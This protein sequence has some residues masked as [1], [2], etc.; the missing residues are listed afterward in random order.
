MEPKREENNEEIWRF[1]FDSVSRR[2]WREKILILR[3]IKLLNVLTSTMDNEEA[4]AASDGGNLM[5]WKRRLM[6][7]AGRREA[8]SNLTEDDEKLKGSCG[9]GVNGEKAFKSFQLH[10]SGKLFP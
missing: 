10:L 6:W 7:W 9:G 4:R 5:P 2:A 3:P 8:F 1:P